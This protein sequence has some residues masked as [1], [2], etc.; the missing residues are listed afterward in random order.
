MKEGYGEGVISKL[1][2]RCPQRGEGVSVWR[3]GAAPSPPALTAYP[4][5]GWPL[6]PHRLH[7]SK[8]LA[9]RDHE[10]NC[11]RFRGIVTFDK[12]LSERSQG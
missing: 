11:N 8:W 4:T 10:G 9:Q 2:M 7:R 3:K 1:E 6:P 5:P 12:N